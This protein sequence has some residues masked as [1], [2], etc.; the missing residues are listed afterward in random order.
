MDS[1]KDVATQVPET[2]VDVQ[3]AKLDVVTREFV[4]AATENAET[5]DQ[6]D[7]RR[8]KVAIAKIDFRAQVKRFE[9]AIAQAVKEPP[10]P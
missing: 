7:R 10:K 5:K 8:H 2:D 4:A 3:Q 1:P 6:R 9:L